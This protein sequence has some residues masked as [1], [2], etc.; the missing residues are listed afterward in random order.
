MKW[1]VNWRNLYRGLKMAGTALCAGLSYFAA[2]MPELPPAVRVGI[3]SLVAALV[4][5]GI[6]VTPSPL[7]QSDLPAL[8]GPDVIEGARNGTGSD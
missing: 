6:Y 1:R 4:A 7:H 3:G 8:V 2:N 5:V